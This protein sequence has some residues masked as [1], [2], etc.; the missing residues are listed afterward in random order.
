MGRDRVSFDYCLRP[1]A[2]EGFAIANERLA[3]CAER[4]ADSDR[5]C[6]TAHCRL[7]YLRINLAGAAWVEESG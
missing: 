6:S 1:V 3:E 2:G 4:V 5:H 7:W